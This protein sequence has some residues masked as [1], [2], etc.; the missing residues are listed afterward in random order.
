MSVF[1]IWNKEIKGKLWAAGDIHGCYNLLM[2]RLKEIGFDFENDLLVAVGDLVDRGSQNIECVNLI[3]EP[4]FTSIKG[5]HEDLCIRGLNNDS[6]YRCH[7]EN[8]G[9]WFYDL[10][11]P[12][13]QKIIGKL[14]ELPV[15]LE[16][17]HRGKKFG[18]VHGHIEQNDWNE[19]KRILS[20]FDQV[21]YVIERKRLPTEIAMW[22][23]DR[24]D[25]DNKQYTHV[26]GVDAVI[27]GHTVT[28]KPCKRDNCYYIDTGAVHWGTLTIL[29]LSKV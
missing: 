20:E 29:D 24:I 14:R 21:R 22:G 28:Q 2:S 6:Y 12:T 9:E 1:K 23:R 11:Y 25:P 3:D 27:M 19:F 8:G 16:V 10:G 18:F 15:A 26:S 5:N 4:W 17:K 13:Q 7:I